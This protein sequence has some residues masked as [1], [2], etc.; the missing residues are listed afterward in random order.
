[1][2]TF[3]AGDQALAVAAGRAV[4]IPDERTVQA[5]AA[6]PAGSF[7]LGVAPLVQGD[8]IWAL[9]NAFNRVGIYSERADA[10]YAKVATGIKAIATVPTVTGQQ[11]ALAEQNLIA[12]GCRVGTRTYVVNAAPKG[13]VTVQVPTASA[14][15][16]GVPV[17]LTI[18]L[19]P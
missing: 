11:E 14:R 9:R 10:F 13:Q 17:N 3:A 12:A 1:M 2:A 4:G 16:V 15:E 18:S 8:M 6:F 19:G 5:F 7:D